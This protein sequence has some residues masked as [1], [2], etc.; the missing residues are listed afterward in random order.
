MPTFPEGFW[1]GKNSEFQSTKFRVL[2]KIR[3]QSIGTQSVSS[4][5]IKGRGLRKGH[6][7]FSGILN[8]KKEFFPLCSVTSLIH[9]VKKTSL[10]PGKNLSLLRE[11]TQL[12]TG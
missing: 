11:N 1:V 6:R 4:A 2:Q 3:A 9:C 8:R 7:V 12:M 5:G 10:S